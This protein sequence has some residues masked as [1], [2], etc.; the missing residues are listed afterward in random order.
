ML[1]DKWLNVLLVT[2]LFLF[3]LLLIYFYY[4]FMG[5]EYEGK[6]IVEYFAKKRAA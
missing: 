1:S 2:W 4:L 6:T 5:H 3:L